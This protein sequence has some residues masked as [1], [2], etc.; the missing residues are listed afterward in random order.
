MKLHK[1]NENIFENDLV[2][3]KATKPIRTSGHSLLKFSFHAEVDNSSDYD[4]AQ[5]EI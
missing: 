3:R 2:S 5:S 4:G 1:V